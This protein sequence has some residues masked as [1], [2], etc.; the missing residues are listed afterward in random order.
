MLFNIHLTLGELFIFRAKNRLLPTT[1]TTPPVMSH[2]LSKVGIED[3]A[4]TYGDGEPRV[5]LLFQGI[6]RSAVGANELRWLVLLG[7]CGP[8]SL[9]RWQRK[10]SAGTLV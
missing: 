4:D 1:T 8:V 9:I 5:P 10:P 3:C 6:Q 7:A 2:S